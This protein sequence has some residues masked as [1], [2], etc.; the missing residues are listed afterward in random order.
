MSVEGML[1]ACGKLPAHLSGQQHVARVC[2]HCVQWWQLA[3]EQVR[4]KL[5]VEL[6][7]VLC[8]LLLYTPPPKTTCSALPQQGARLTVPSSTEVQVTLTA[9]GVQDITFICAY[10]YR[11]RA[12]TTFA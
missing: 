10:I 6:V 1:G 11:I 2:Y 7:V 4:V 8:S 12:E 3:D 9:G 5:R